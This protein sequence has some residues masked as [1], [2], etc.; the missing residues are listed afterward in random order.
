MSSANLSDA[1]S[2]INCAIAVES[3][4]YLH[5]NNHRIPTK[6]GFIWAH[7]QGVPCRHFPNPITNLC[8]AQKK[9]RSY[10]EARLLYTLT[11]EQQKE[12]SASMRI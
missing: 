12:E 1:K 4:F 11:S 2:T 9:P 8:M 10:Q 5:N 3:R 6:N 7:T